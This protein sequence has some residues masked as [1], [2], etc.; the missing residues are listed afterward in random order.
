MKSWNLDLYRI[1]GKETI[2]IKTLFLFVVL[3]MIGLMSS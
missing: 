1:D 3:N 2:E